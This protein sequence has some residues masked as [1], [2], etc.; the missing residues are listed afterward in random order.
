MDYNKIDHLNKLLRMEIYKFACKYDLAECIND[1]G[2]NL[3]SDI[4]LRLTRFCMDAKNLNSMNSDLN[5]IRRLNFITSSK[6]NY[7]ENLDELNEVISA[8][9]CAKN[10]III[11]S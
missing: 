3:K 8:M 2:G 10:K 9:G 1:G 5:L 6:A 4:D 7:Y 11:Q